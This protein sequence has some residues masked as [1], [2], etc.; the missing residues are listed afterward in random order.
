VLESGFAELTGTAPRRILLAAQRVLPASLA[1]KGRGGEAGADMLPSL[2]ARSPFG[3]GF[4]AER[5][6]QALHFALGLSAYRPED[7]MSAAAAR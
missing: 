4:S 3:D 1:A 7:Y 2:S 5:I 6:Q